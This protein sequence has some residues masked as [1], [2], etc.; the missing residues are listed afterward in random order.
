VI[1]WSLACH[2]FPWSVFRICSSLDISAAEWGV[3]RGRRRSLSQKASW[4]FL[5][6]FSPL[7]FVCLHID[8]WRRCCGVSRS[9]S[10]SCAE[11][12]GGPGEVCVGD[13]FVWWSAL[14]GG[15]R[16]TL[17]SA[18]VKEENWT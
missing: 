18:L 1:Q 3:S 10:T 7:A 17:L 4:S 9:R 13:D 12:R 16:K 2:G 5:R 14:C 6:R 11:C 8:S 15:L